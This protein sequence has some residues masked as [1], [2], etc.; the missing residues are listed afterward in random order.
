MPL[1]TLKDTV[2]IFH[3]ISKLP[4]LDIWERVV[5]LGW[6]SFL[7]YVRKGRFQLEGQISCG[8]IEI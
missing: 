4:A 8:G 2:Q 1:V 5:R 7:D 6:Q 3:W